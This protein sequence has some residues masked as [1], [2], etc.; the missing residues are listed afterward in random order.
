MTNFDAIKNMSVDE[1]ARF[2]ATVFGQGEIY[3]ETV[4]S[5]YRGK[6]TIS[7]DEAFDDGMGWC[8]E[9]T[10][11]K[12]LKSESPDGAVSAPDIKY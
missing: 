8:F 2:L 12:F 10:Y 1:F 11:K 3:G 7:G 5:D 4:R 9:K 6:R